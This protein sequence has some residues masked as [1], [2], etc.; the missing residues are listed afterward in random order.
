MG[1][2]Y[3]R[4]QKHTP[5]FSSMMNSQKRAMIMYF[6]IPPSDAFER[7][8]HMEYVRILPVQNEKSPTDSKALPQ[9]PSCA[10]ATI[11]NKGGLVINGDER[12]GIV[13]NGKI[14]MSRDDLYKEVKQERM[15]PSEGVGET[16][17][18]EDEIS[19]VI[20]QANVPR[21]Q[22]VEALYKTGNI[23]DAI[24]TLA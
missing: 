15:K 6:G 11:S 17:F 13:Y 9:V 16:P 20:S 21:A 2:K 12:P 3:D 23:V 7:G 5:L 8:K 10:V 1:N 24:L 4:V 14:Y 22:A 19:T 18:D